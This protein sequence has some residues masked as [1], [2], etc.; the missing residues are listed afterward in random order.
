MPKTSKPRLSAVR[1]TARSTAL[2]PGAS[3]PPVL[4]A[5]RQLCMRQSRGGNDMS[6][7]HHTRQRV[8][9]C[10]EFGHTAVSEMGQHGLEGGAVAAAEQL[11]DRHLRAGDDRP[12]RLHAA[13]ADGAVLRGARADRVGGDVDGAALGQRAEHRLRDA[14]VASTPATRSWSRSRARASR[15]AKSG[16]AE[17]A[18]RRPCRRADLGPA[19]RAPRDR[20]RP[21]R[22][23]TGW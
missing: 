23:G 5:R 1:V 17:A 22:A 9:V 8:G 6:W 3:P 15:A 19:R 21:A 10:I 12:R 7:R 4:T 20:C 13:Q 18:E 16:V 2:R 11:V 14:D